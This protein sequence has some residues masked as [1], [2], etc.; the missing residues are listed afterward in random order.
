MVV[1]NLN[2]LTGHDQLDPPELYSELGI[3]VGPL[4][5]RGRSCASCDRPLV[6]DAQ[7]ATRSATSPSF[8]RY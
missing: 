8:W 2:H 4:F 3:G 1:R 5:A 7:L 6:V